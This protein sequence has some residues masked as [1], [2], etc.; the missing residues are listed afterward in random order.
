MVPLTKS[1]DPWPD[2]E[3]GGGPQL[4]AADSLNVSSRFRASILRVK[5][6]ENPPLK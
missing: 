3:I 5:S 2:T 1:A 6:V 4:Q